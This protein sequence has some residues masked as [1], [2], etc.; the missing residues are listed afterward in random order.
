M[1]STR[2]YLLRAIYDWIVDNG[3]TPHLLVEVRDARVQVPRQYIENGAIVLNVSPNAVRDLE[4]GNDFIVF[5][6]RFSGTAHDISVPLE[7]VQAIYAR[8]N[9]QGIFLGEVGEE[10]EGAEP[11]DEETRGDASSDGTTSA[12]AEVPSRRAPHLKIVK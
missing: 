11:N 2:P 7:A 10:V 8:E 6:A 9:G 3:H 5:N 4:L 12:G 1:T